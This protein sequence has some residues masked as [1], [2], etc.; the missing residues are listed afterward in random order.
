M[1]ELLIPLNLQLNQHLIERAWQEPQFQQQLIEQPRKTLELSLNVDLPD[2][3]AYQIVKDTINNYHLILPYVPANTSVAESQR[4]YT[5]A[6]SIYDQ[7]WQ[8][9]L[10]NLFQKAEDTSFRNTLLNQPKAT[11]AEF[12][13]LVLPDELNITLIENN[14][15]DRY[16]V[17]PHNTLR[18]TRKVNKELSNINLALLAG[19]VSSS[20]GA[21]ANVIETPTEKC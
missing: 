15:T 7:S 8:T 19:A 18:Q 4:I 12:L 14:I 6:A 11:L 21:S 5:K 13:G 1:L 10:V 16:L 3:V 20:S 2:A 17:L 9:E